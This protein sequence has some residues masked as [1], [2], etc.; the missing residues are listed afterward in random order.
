MSSL[1]DFLLTQIIANGAP[2]FG[3]ALLLGALGFPVPGTLLVVA[4]GAFV[5]QGALE[6]VESAAFGLIGA[7]AGDSLSFGLG[8]V[9]RGWVQHRFG[10]ASIWQSAQSSFARSGRLAVYL[11][12]FFLTAIAIPVN[13]LAGGSG[14][15]YGR[16]LLYDLLGEV[17]WLAL[18]GGLG[19]LFGGQWELISQFLSDFGG[20]TFGIAMMGA[21]AYFWIKQRNKTQ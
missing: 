8:R 21:G 14:C 9:A 3:L 20:L 19:W 7:V 10:T 18:Y 13:L 12:R 1:S 4:A 17:T 2:L 16:F 5:K 6:G 15:P 11:S